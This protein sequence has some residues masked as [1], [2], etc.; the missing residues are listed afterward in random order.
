M[1]I[2]SEWIDNINP[3][4]AMIL[5]HDANPKSDW[6]FRKGHSSTRLLVLPFAISAVEDK[7]SN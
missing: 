5:T 3:D 7:R 4:H 2:P 6:N 1:N